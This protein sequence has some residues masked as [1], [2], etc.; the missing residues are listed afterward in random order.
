MKRD[1]KK[2]ERWV[3][4]LLYEENAHTGCCIEILAEEIVE[5]VYN[6]LE[7]EDKQCLDCVKN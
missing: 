2:L 7:E 3:K 4:D 5:A 6:W 1:K